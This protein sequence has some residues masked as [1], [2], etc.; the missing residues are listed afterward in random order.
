MLKFE[1]DFHVS[2]D[3]IF[4]IIALAILV[5][6]LLPPSPCP[7]DDESSDDYEETGCSDEHTDDYDECVD[8]ECAS[9]ES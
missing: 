8:E 6:H 4:T 3:Q 1:L 9:S 2:A 5:I 7:S